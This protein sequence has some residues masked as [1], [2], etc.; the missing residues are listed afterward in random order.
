MSDKR[1]AP[2]GIFDSGIGGVSTLGQAVHMMPHEEF[3][4]YGD[5]GNGPYSLKTKEQVKKYCVDAC[6][7]LV[8]QGC[9]AIVVA[10][11]TATVVAIVEMREA[12]PQ[13]PILGMEPA[14]KVAVSYD[15][16]GKIAVMATGMTLKSRMLNRLIERFAQ[17]YQVVK[18]HGRETIKLIESG[19]ID[20]KQMQESLA[21]YFKEHD[22]KDISVVVFGCTHFGVLEPCIK[23]LLGE[24]VLIA[25]GNQGTIRH[26][27]NILRE[28]GQLNPG[29]R[30]RRE[31]KFHN[32]G[33]ESSL[34]N[35]IKN[36][37]KHL[38]NLRG[39]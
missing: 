23:N 10:C 1:Y 28:K 26:L 37:E 5:N 21:F 9:K 3:I 35:S 27:E 38:A 39:R 31:V 16:Q 12:F 33:S 2:I 25:D 17:G 29:D 22:P 11:N 30:P 4:Y 32:T 7:Y 14:V 6:G 24:H 36:Y 13:L 18:V 20:G 8:D 34:N 15:P 19:V